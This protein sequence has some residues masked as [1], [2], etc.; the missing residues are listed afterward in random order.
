MEAVPM[1]AVPMEMIMMEVASVEVVASVVVVVMVVVVMEVASDKR[2]QD[3][4]GYLT[5]KYPVNGLSLNNIHI[6]RG[7][8]RIS[9]NSWAFA[10]CVL[11]YGNFQDS[12]QGTTNTKQPIVKK[13]QD[14]HIF[15]ARTF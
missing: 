10:G 8:D 14:T 6:S 4:C 7:A 12:S 5:E 13:K 3:T 1:E 11:K 2:D 9:I 15:L